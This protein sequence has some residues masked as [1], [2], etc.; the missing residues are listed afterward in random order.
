M[1]KLHAAEQ[2]LFAAFTEELSRIESTNIDLPGAETAIELCRLYLLQLKALVQEHG[3]ADKDEEIVFF[4]HRKPLYL[5]PLIYYTAIYTLYSQWPEGSEIMKREYLERELNRLKQFF[6]E[7]H[8]LYVYC[9]SRS[10]HMDNK[11]F[12]RGQFDVH[13]SHDSFYLEADARFSTGYDLLVSQITANTRLLIYIEKLLL[14]PVSSASVSPSADSSNTPSLRWTGS[15]ID[16]VELIYAL[17]L[18][19]VFNN[20]KADVKLIATRLQQVFDIDLGNYYN[21]FQDMR[22]RKTGQTKYLDHM[23]AML[24]K[25][26]DE[27]E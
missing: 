7:H 15:K 2:E 25:K 21:I 18:T 4:K 5:V 9:R 3:F 23:K 22:R 13:L 6:A 12:V 16:L 20:G 19:D 11:Y 26:L 24:T 27:I 17:H 14:Q 1:K 10:T 8:T